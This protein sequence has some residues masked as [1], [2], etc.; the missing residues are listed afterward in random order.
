MLVQRT[1][2]S[3]RTLFQKLSRNLLQTTTSGWK[4]EKIRHRFAVE[5]RKW[6]TSW[7]SSISHPEPNPRGMLLQIQTF[8]PRK[9]R[10]TFGENNPWLDSRALFLGS[11][12][13][14]FWHKFGLLNFN[15]SRN[16]D[17]PMIS[18]SH[19]HRIIF[20]YQSIVLHFD[21]NWWLISQNLQNTIKYNKLLKY[22]FWL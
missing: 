4:I 22:M 1:S 14:S 16:F 10:L 5:I 19:Y 9:F 8:L 3:C 2:F 15:V 20:K 7:L 17:T 18:N 13:Y 12:N 21:P 6:I 11:M